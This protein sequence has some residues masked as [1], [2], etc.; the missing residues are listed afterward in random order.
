ML[1]RRQMLTLLTS[2]GIG[3]GVLHRAVATL[4]QDKDEL[5]AELIRQAEWITGLELT[6]QERESLVGSVK[7]ANSQLESL[8][9][10]E[11]DASV[12]PATHFQTLTGSRDPGSQVRRGAQPKDWSSAALPGND[13]DIAFLPVTEL[14]ALIRSRKISSVRLTQIYLNRLKKYGPML[15]CVVNLTEELAIKQARQADREIAAGRYRGPL[16]GIPWGAKDLIAVD[17]Y[18][19]TWG[20]P[21]YQERIL[22]ETATV[23]RRLEQAGAVLVAKLSLGA[24]AMGDKWYGGLTRNPWNAKQGSSGSSAGSASA[25]VA[26]LVGFSLGSETLGSILSPCT[27]CGAS[28]LR[29]TFGRVSRH[30]CMPLSWTMDKIGPICRSL[31]DCAL[32]FDAIHGADGQDHTASSFP[33]Q[34]PNSTHVSRLK[35][36]IRKGRQEIEEREDLA[37][38]REMGCEFV[39]I[40]LPRDIP[41]RALTKIIDVEGAS[42]FDQL[43]REGETDGW[44]TW[45]R[46]FQAAQ[47]ISAIDYLRFQR[48]RTQLMHRFEETIANVDVLFNCNDLVHTNFTGHPSA[49]LPRAFRA[50]RS[51]GGKS[52]TAAVFTGHLNQESTLLAIAS[53]YQSRLDTHL[54]RPPIDDWLTQFDEG[55]LDKRP[56]KEE[57]KAKPDD[58][59]SGTSGDG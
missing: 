34:W 3:T 47:F 6:D 7:Q 40:S 54:E 45:T 8:R 36:G 41:L 43:L 52:P 49:V 20:I 9:E 33:F 25:T 16:H 4:A 11:L 13:D 37:P 53:E 56:A 29:P 2:T 19:T 17:G 44:N 38:L 30:G 14:A 51:N 21:V 18:P 48:V 28:G 22:S 1:D 42:V 55:T 50:S 27:R 39:E 46:T 5:N 26:G 10:F 12:A 57:T 59:K 23:A 35:V 58:T 24:I 15:R 31:E 32:V